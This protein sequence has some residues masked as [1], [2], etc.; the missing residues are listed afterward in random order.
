MSS[1][2]LNTFF[3]WRKSTFCCSIC[4]LTQNS[5]RKHTKMAYNFMHLSIIK[6]GQDQESTPSL[7]FPRSRSLALVPSLS[8]PRSQPRVLFPTL[9]SPRTLPLAF[10][11]SFSSLA[12]HPTFSS[13]C[14]LPLALICTL[15]RSRAPIPLLS[16]PN[17]RHSFLTPLRFFEHVPTPFIRF[18]LTDRASLYT[19]CVWLS[20]L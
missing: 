9:S 13:P 2:N 7:S 4:P 17:S 8:F 3:K 10:V 14:S 20:G 11:P 1:G 19:S 15:C 16:S 6:R 12:L 5:P 18:F